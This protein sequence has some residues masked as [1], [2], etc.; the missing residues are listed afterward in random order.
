M[1]CSI[2]LRTLWVLWIVWPALGGCKTPPPL[3]AVDPG[4]FEAEIRA[5][6]AADLERP[7]G[8]GGLL[9]VGSSSIRLWNLEE[10]FPGSGALNR[11]F[12]GSHISDCVAFTPRIVLPYKPRVIVFYAG[13]NDIAAGKSAEVCLQ[14]WNRFVGAVRAKLP[15]VRILF[16]SI[17]PSPSRWSFWPEASRANE[18][19]RLSCE[20][21]QGGLEYID[22]ARPLLGADGLP[23][24]EYY[25]EDH[26]HLSR[27]GYARWAKVL[28]PVIERFLSSRDAQP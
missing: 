14:D 25:V 23:V 13:D 10:S 18:L 20:A 6:E 3:P 21:S 9:F 27:S 5:F 4:R 7:P 8:V 15:G 24:A 12:G 2:P 19:I 11:G 26:L 28:A 22:V 16:L 1:S 17:K